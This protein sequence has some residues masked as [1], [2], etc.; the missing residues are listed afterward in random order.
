MGYS[1]GFFARRDPERR[2]LRDA[3]RTRF[4]SDLGVERSGDPFS[5]SPT[6]DTQNTLVE[7][8]LMDASRDLGADDEAVQIM[9]RSIRNIGFGNQDVKQNHSNLLFSA[10]SPTAFADNFFINHWGNQPGEAVESS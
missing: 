3:T 1:D 7:K 2:A 6:S 9:L 8:L 10:L 5:D 4:F